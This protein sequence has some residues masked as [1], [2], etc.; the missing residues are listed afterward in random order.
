MKGHLHWVGK[1][2]KRGG[3]GKIDLTVGQQHTNHHP[4][5]AQRLYDLNVVLHGVIFIVA[6]KKITGTG[7]NDRKNRHF[8]EFSATTKCSIGW[9]GSSFA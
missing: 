9:R 1:L 8:K 2:T 3:A 5:K 7:T 4:F 6:I